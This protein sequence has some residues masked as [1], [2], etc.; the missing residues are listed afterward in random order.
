MLVITIRENVLN[1]DLKDIY[2][3][4]YTLYIIQSVEFTFWSWLVDM[5]KDMMNH[6]MMYRPYLA[7]YENVSCVN[8]LYSE[9]AFWWKL[10]DWNFQ[11]RTLRRVLFARRL[12]LI[13]LIL[14]K[15]KKKEKKKELH[16]AFPVINTKPLSL[17]YECIKKTYIH[18]TVLGKF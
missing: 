10:S 1:V 16:Q 13:E 4:Q 18:R 2:I 7:M 12:L 9:N 3:V 8:L 17:F 14:M 6:S 11:S 5:M 15:A